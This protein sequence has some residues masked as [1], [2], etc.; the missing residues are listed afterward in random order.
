MRR[1]LGAV[2]I[3]LGALLLVAAGGLVLVVAPAVTK[4]PYDM[5]PCPK[6]NPPPGCLKPSVAEARNATFLQIGADIKINTGDLRSTTEVI[7]Q[8][9]TT[10]DEQSHN[11]LT[12]AIVWD[13]YST[14]ARIDDGTVITQSSTELALDRASGA[15][16]TD[17]KGQWI[18]ESKDVKDTSIAYKGQVYKFPF[19]TEK[20][21]YPYWDSDTRTAPAAKFT[22]VESIEGVETYHFVQTIPPTAVAVADESLAVLIS[23][24]APTA[25]SGQVLYNNVREVWVDPVTGSFIKVREQPHQTFKPNVGATVDLLD[26]DFVY[27]TD[28]IKNSAQSAKDNG[29]KLSLITLYLPIAA[30]VV[31]LVLLIGGFLMLRARTPK[32]ASAGGA[33][34]TMDAELPAARHS[35]RG[36]NEENTVW[37][38]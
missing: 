17:W 32:A 4:L 13:V 34:A 15:A 24:F 3:G 10:A 11:R 19:G 21:D 12:D 25:T 31:G 38:T 36:E 7:P 29:F 37:T 6:E 30:A 23:T 2:L 22:S 33:D 8:A 28:T 9:K 5:V 16:V 26:A 35:L 1:L 18:S 14:A 27:T 20:K